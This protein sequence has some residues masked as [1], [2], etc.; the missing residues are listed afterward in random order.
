MKRFIRVVDDFYADPQA[1][2]RRALEMTYTEPENLVGWRTKAYQPRGIRQR[3]ESRFGVRI[4]YW[5][6]DLDAI[7][8]C[9]GV[10]FTSYA[11]GARSERVG[12]H[13]D[14]PPR[15]V[16]F[17]IYLTPDAPYDAGTSL[18]QHRKTGIVAKPTRRDA[19]RLGIPLDELFATIEHDAKIRGRWI[20]ID[21]VGNVFNRAVM[22]PGG[23]YHSASRHFGSGFR[24]GRIYQSF[25]FPVELLR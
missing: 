10:F 7:E 12:I 14:D 15:W 19:E 17:L 24:D 22:F 20:E 2:R 16:M 3:I 25:H 6:A 9:N 1:V 8:A 23:F 13:F 11:K 5:E 4:P 18:W 21:R